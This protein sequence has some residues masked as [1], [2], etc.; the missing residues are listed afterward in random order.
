MTNEC[1][2]CMTPFDEN[3]SKVSLGCSHTFHYSCILRWNLQSESA[4]HSSCPLCREEIDVDGALDSV[5]QHQ[6]QHQ[7][8]HRTQQVRVD[9]IIHNPTHGLRVRCIDCNSE[10]NTCDCCGI[11]V[12]ACQFQLDM[13]DW[14]SRSF[15]CPANPFHEEYTDLE[16]GEIPPITCYRCF[17]SRE[18][19][20][21]DFMM[22]DHGDGDIFYHEN[23]QEMYETYFNDNS[24]RDNTQIY[25]QYPT[26]SF[27]EFREHMERLFQEE[28][29]NGI[30]LLDEDIYDDGEEVPN[31]PIQHIN[32]DEL[33]EFIEDIETTN[34][35]VQTFNEPERINPIINNNAD[36]NS[37]R[38]IAMPPIELFTHLENPTINEENLHEVIQNNDHR[39]NE[40]RHNT[41]IRFVNNIDYY[42]NDSVRNQN[43]RT[44]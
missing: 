43:Q 44:I 2:I 42:I 39:N 12:C 26:Y 20:V 30:N 15:H 19:R 7:H 32:L 1:S 13:R 23:M 22:D 41:Y 5:R 31:P 27:A 34:Y 10:F 8:Q 3:N 35:Q 24:G 29:D 38:P 18:E 14:E 11:S 6:H 40:Y 36:N 21:L 16:E 25:T 4:N 33:Q 9:D 17:V 37:N 28:M